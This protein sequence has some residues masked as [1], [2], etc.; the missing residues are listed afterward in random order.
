M[1]IK[2]LR[3]LKIQKE[4]KKDREKLVTKKKKRK[5]FR[6]RQDNICSNALMIKYTWRKKTH[7]FPVKRN[8]RSKKTNQ[9]SNNGTNN[10]A[11][12]LTKK[13]HLCLYDVRRRKKWSEKK[14]TRKGWNDSNNVMSVTR[15]RTLQMGNQRLDG[16][17]GKKERTQNTARLRN[18]ESVAMKPKWIRESK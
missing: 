16:M 17:K 12:L 5:N 13:I 14:V 6:N 8:K 18:Y 4:K 1:T 15:R 7:S 2:T 10:Q 9:E 11:K 3:K